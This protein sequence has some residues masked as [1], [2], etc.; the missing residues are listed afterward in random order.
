MAKPKTVYKVK[1]FRYDMDVFGVSQLHVDQFRYYDKDLAE[2]RF[3]D[4]TESGKYYKTEY[5]VLD[6]LYKY[7]KK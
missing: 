3:I 2:N 4:M 1:G 5:I 7:P 6:N